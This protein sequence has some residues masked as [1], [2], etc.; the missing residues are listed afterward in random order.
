MATSTAAAASPDLPS[1]QP[2]S[3]VLTEHPAHSA[4]GIP[5]LVLA[6]AVLLAGVVLVVLAAGGGGG[7]ATGLGIAAVALVRPAW[8]SCSGGTP[9]QSGSLA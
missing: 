8:C 9:A 4:P 3:P 5:V 1:R 2:A 6:C 7:L